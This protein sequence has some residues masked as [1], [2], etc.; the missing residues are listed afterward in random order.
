MERKEEV[1]QDDSDVKSAEQGRAGRDSLGKAGAGVSHEIYV[2]TTTGPGSR[3]VEEIRATP[4]HIGPKSKK[5]EWDLHLVHRSQ[6]LDNDLHHTYQSQAA[7]RHHQ[8]IAPFLKE[9]KQP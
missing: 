6:S 4:I 1:E 9:K 8:T 3:E 2:T 5:L 7:P